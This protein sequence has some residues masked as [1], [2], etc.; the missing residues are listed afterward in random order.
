VLVLVFRGERDAGGDCGSE[1]RSVAGID[2]A[3]GPGAV[4]VIHVEAARRGYGIDVELE[5]GLGDVGAGVAGGD[6]RQIELNV[7][8]LRALNIEYGFRTEVRGGSGRVGVG[9]AAGR[10]LAKSAGQQ[11]YCG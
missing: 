10:K 11:T 4:D 6:R 9:I 5:R 3:L 2:R 8:G 1:R 7:S